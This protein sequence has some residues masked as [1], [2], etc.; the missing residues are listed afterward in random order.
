MQQ[1]ALRTGS[2]AG[3]RATSMPIR[4][5]SAQQKA[6]GRSSSASAQ[7]AAVMMPSSSSAFLRSAGLKL[8]VMRGKA[9]GGR[10]H[11]VRPVARRGRC[12]ARRLLPPL[13]L[14]LLPRHRQLRMLR[15]VL[16]LMAHQHHHLMG[17]KGQAAAHLAATE[18]NRAAADPF[19]SLAAL[20]MAAPTSQGL[21]PDVRHHRHLQA[22]GLR[23]RGAV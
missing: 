3:G 5:S 22:R 4:A 23:Q 17:R 13:L 9:G 6:S 1:Q 11:G 14:L 20:P 2:C 12:A 18:L 7:R 19:L 8:S 10:S 21:P 15:V 16:L